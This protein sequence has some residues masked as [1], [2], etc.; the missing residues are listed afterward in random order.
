MLCA[1]LP[2]RF[3]IFVQCYNNWDHKTVSHLR[4]NSRAQHVQAVLSCV[5][6]SSTHTPTRRLARQADMAA[7]TAGQ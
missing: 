6:H 5:L 3:Y 7:G 2:R 1:A 4:A